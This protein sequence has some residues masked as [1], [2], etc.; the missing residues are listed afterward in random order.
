MHAARV[1]TILQTAFRA[2]SAYC[3]TALQLFD[4][5]FETAMSVGSGDIPVRF[6]CGYIEPL[7]GE[8]EIASTEEQPGAIIAMENEFE[9]AVRAS[10]KPEGE[11]GLAH[12]SQ[13][14]IERS[15]ELVVAIVN[16]QST[17]VIDAPHLDLELDLAHCPTLA[18]VT[19]HRAY[20]QLR[21]KRLI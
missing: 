2:H 9:I 18:P 14:T 20:S 19:A 7:Q 6:S 16:P 12:L 13:V 15:D 3:E 4:S 8:S 10:K 11:F 5:I 21:I 17:D 1:A